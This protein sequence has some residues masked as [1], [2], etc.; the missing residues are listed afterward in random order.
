MGK[1]GA[2]GS[3]GSTSQTKTVVVKD[4]SDTKIAALLIIDRELQRLHEALEMGS[5]D[6]DETQSQIS[7]LQ[8]EL[9]RVSRSS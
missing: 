4:V 5:G 1:D 2:G 6:E 9:I 3:Y 7:D 8:E